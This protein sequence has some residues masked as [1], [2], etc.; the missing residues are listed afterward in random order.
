MIN[1]NN[2]VLASTRKI[3]P[4]F[5][6][7]ITIAVAA[8]VYAMINI[9]RLPTPEE[10]REAF[11]Q[12]I[13][14]AMI[15]EE[16]QATGLS[17]EEVKR[18]WQKRD[19][20]QRLMVE[21]NNGINQ[22]DNKLVSESLR[23]LTKMDFYE[24]G[25]FVF[26][27]AIVVDNEKAF[28][29][30]LKKGIPCN[31]QSA[32][33]KSAFQAAISTAN[34]SYIKMLLDN[35]CGYEKNSKQPSL[36]DRII[37]SAHPDKLFLL[38]EKYINPDYKNRAFLNALKRGMYEQVQTMLN[39]GANPNIPN[40]LTASL[41][42]SDSKISFLL[43]NNGADITAKSTKGVHVLTTALMKGKVDVAREIL[44]RDPDYIQREKIEHRILSYI[45][46]LSKNSNC[47]TRIHC[48]AS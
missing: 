6:I 36:E 45:F 24:T 42:A 7:L 16:V 40:S 30:L 23:K 14:N 28:R 20:K 35:N 44:R 21:L 9:G 8:F 15:A 12:Q 18:R 37:N 13:K 25:G 46:N 26:R 27:N 31:N 4:I 33:G 41:F 29:I 17:P 48:F 2:Y 32:T 22:K 10:K 43:I 47:C 34:P 19:E 11:D 3:S 39:L 1:K 5:V 38:S